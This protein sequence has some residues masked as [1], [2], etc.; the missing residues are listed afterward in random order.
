[1]VFTEYAATLDWIAG[2]LAVFELLAT[3]RLRVFASCSNWFSEF[4]K[5]QRV[6]SFPNKPLKRDDHLM[7]ATRY[8]VV[9]GRDRM[10]TEPPPALRL[11]RFPTRKK[12]W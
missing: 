11:Y 5:Y 12:F 9:S 2:I 8:L 1:M 10:R 4:R 3:G 6:E 7:D